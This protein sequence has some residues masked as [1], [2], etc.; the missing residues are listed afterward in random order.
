MAV[1]DAASTKVTPG[2]LS[3]AVYLYIRQSTLRQVHENTAST[4]R[5]YGLRQRATALG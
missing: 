5:Q 4:E 2:H 3:R 1:S